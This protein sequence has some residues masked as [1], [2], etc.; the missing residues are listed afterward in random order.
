MPNIRSYDAPQG[1]G[2]NPSELGVDARAAAARR[3]GS[4][5][6]AAGEAIGDTGRRVAS[7]VSDIGETVV[8]H[9]DMRDRG[10][11]SAAATGTLANIDKAWTLKTKGNG[12]DPK[13]PNYI[14][15]ADPRDPNLADKFMQDN[16][17]PALDKLNDIAVGANGQKFAQ[18]KIDQIRN[19]LSEKFTA[20][21]S[22]MAGEAA[23]LQD[24]QTTNNLSNLVTTSPDFHSVDMALQMHKDAAAGWKSNPNVSGVQAGKMDEHFQLSQE[25]IV[26]AAAA[27]AISKSSNPVATAAAF[28]KQYPNYIKGDVVNQL[29]KAAEAQTKVNTYHDKSAVVAQRQLDDLNVHRSA[30]D[31]LS[32]NVSIDPQSGRPIINPQYFN[33]ALEIAKRNPDAP[34]AAATARTMIDW[35]ESQMNKSDHA[36]DPATASTIDA[37]MFVPENPTTKMDIMRAEADKKMSSADASLRMKIIDQRDKLPTDPQF[38]FAM[39][40]AKQLID[41]RTPGERS[42]QAG[43]YATF[44]QE[45]LPEYQRQKAAGTLPPNALSLRDPNSLLSKSMEAYK[46]PLAAAISGNGGIGIAPTPQAA[47]SMPTVTSKAEFDGLKSGAV[48]IGKDGKTFRKP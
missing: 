7:T 35:G 42:M 40:G 44:M 8:S 30:A 20:D 6:N 33:D 12:L 26:H 18:E 37:R 10:D 11:I 16:V 36:T 28:S 31:T 9:I 27:A 17:Q 3:A 39:D 19:H 24:R 34:S 41:G 4:F 2:L 1:L 32:K 48:Y 15:P 23:V 25:Q 43:K 29:A 22:T 5:Y 21:M 38:K 14:P 46:S 13:D 45:F 47:A